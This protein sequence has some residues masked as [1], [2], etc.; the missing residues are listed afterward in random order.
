MR[1]RRESPPPRMQGIGN[2][3]ENRY[4]T[5]DTETHCEDMESQG[6]ELAPNVTNC[7]PEKNFS[8]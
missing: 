4:W 6:R 7:W 3:S 8:S 2:S 5:D 1:E